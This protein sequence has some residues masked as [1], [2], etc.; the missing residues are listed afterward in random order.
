M[1]RGVSLPVV[2]AAQYGTPNI[3]SDIP[4]FREIAGNHAAY[5]GIDDARRLAREISDWWERCEAG[6]IPQ[7]T[8]MPRLS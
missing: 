6:D 3:C 8:V 2:E 4:V 7:S 5:V 1:V